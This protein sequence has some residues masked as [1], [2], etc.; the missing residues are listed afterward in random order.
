MINPDGSSSSGQRPT[1]GA[2]P[3]PAAAPSQPALAPRLVSSKPPQGQPPKPS[4]AP[5]Q[6]AE[7]VRTLPQPGPVPASEFS[8]E[9]SGPRLTV[10]PVI[11][12]NSLRPQEPKTIPKD[13]VEIGELGD[14]PDPKPVE[15]EA[16]IEP[17]KLPKE[18]SVAQPDETPRPLPTPK[19]KPV[20]MTGSP[21]TKPRS[22]KS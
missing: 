11:D 8:R 21:R 22:S 10:N 17:F 13:E 5:Q 16:E 7:T 4:M 2:N 3:T 6:R 20:A 14:A 15:V 12:A 18:D 1:N 19:P 9:S